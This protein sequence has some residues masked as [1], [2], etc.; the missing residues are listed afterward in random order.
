LAAAVA[1]VVI[2]V[3]SAPTGAA[4]AAASL[5]LS[6]NIGPP[7]TVSRAKG[8]GFSGGEAVDITFDGAHV[9]TATARSD[10]SFTKKFRIPAP[11][12]PG[13][14]DVVARGEGSGREASRSFLVRTPWEQ[15]RFDEGHSGLNP[16]EN[17]IGVSNVTALVN[18]W[19]VHTGG[20]VTSSPTYFRG[21]VFEGSSDHRL[22]AIDPSTGATKWTKTLDGPVTATPIGRCAP[23]GPCRVVVVTNSSVGGVYAFDTTGKQLWHATVGD[24]MVAS[25]T[26]VCFPA[27]PCTP[28]VIVADKAGLVEARSIG[29]GA[30]LWK[31][32]VTGAPNAPALATTPPGPPDR[33]L[34]T[35]NMGNLYA[36][37]SADGAVE[38]SAHVSGM[39]TAPA[40]S[41]GFNPQPDPPGF[42]EVVI[43]TDQ[44]G[45]YEFNGETG[46]LNASWTVSGAVA[47]PPAL[48]DVNG[49]GSA[50][51]VVVANI[52]QR[53]GPGGR[54]DPTAVEMTAFGVDGSTIWS[55]NVS[56][57][58]SSAPS[59][60]NGLI[61]L[62]FD[63][64]TLRAFRWSDGVNLFDF[65]TKL[66]VRT[67]PMVADGRVVIGSN[68]DG[69]YELGLPG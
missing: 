41:H 53:H 46:D 38:W 47:K 57:A 13:S 50:D 5:K 61:Y 23:P 32:T 10:G 34:I 27:N 37:S 60:A 68:D 30:M 58:S 8:A 26:D 44:G 7:T 69:I 66:P 35:T 55:T 20:Q 11:A 2:G 40:D 63:D 36:L 42:G 28:Y 17:T 14:H 64:G 19:T 15:F 31:A 22:R 33:V 65:A 52:A 43:G 51:I 4:P 6:P 29:D 45:V 54:P 21:L 56:A 18:G 62:G 9:A 59:M 1:F 39:P 16:Y 24:G 67:S 3:W 12:Q 48:G 49:D 25:P